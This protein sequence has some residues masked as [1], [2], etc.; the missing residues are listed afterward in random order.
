MR[1]RVRQKMLRKL[2]EGEDRYQYESTLAREKYERAKAVEAA[3]AAS[4]MM[5]LQRCLDGAKH[6]RA[7]AGGK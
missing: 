5:D 3:L 2:E 6:F 4:D 7:R 1:E